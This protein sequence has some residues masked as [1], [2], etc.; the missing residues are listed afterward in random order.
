P[1]VGLLSLTGCSGVLPGTLEEKLATNGTEEDYRMAAKMYQ[2]K[3]REL[4][5]EAVQYETAAAKVS[6]DMDPKGFERAALRMAAQEK[7]HDAKE[8]LE[9]SAAEL[10]QARAL[11]SKAEPQ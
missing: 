3:A 7:R 2:K 1:L 5:A 11:H 8:M 10:G 4:E 9:L 6:R